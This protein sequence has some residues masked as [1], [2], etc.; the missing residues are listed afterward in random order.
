MDAETIDKLNRMCPKAKSEGLGTML[1]MAGMVRNSINQSIQAYNEASATQKHDLGARL[2]LDDNRVFRYAYARNII[3]DCR[4]GLKFWDQIGDGIAY[5]APLQTQTVLEST[6][7]IDSGK[8]AGGVTLDQFKGGFCVVHTGT[9]YESQ[10]RGIT[11]NTVAD[12]DGYTTITVDAVWTKAIET[13]YGVEIMAN[14][15]GSVRNASAGGGSGN[16]PNEY[17]SVA[18][19]PMLTTDAADMYLWL[20][21]WGPCWVNPHGTAGTTPT[22]DRRGLVF[23]R[24]GSISA[25]D[26]SVSSDVAQQYAGFIITR[27]SVAGGSAVPLVF[28]QITP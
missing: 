6:V 23:D 19:I 9:D 3:G 10:F 7:L 26:E 22:A 2:A 12:G 8:G 17:S 21:T 14:P 1:S 28:L 11:G 13:G 20:Q 16:T 4:F 25:I 15:W 24:E 27:E 18:G 5:T